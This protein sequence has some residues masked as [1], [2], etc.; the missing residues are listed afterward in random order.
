[1]RF[2]F[3][4]PAFI[5]SFSLSLLYF[6]VLSFSG[7]M[8]TY[9][10]ASNINLWQVGIIRGISTVFEVSATWIAPSLMKRIGVIRT[11]LW[12]VAWQMTWLG[13]GVAWFFYHYGHGYPSADL[14]PAVG[15]ALAVAFSR[16]GLWCFDLSMQNIVQD[17][18]STPSHVVW[19]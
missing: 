18:R 8:L 9:L 16:V 13:G 17:V 3:G 15:L 14:R 2:Y 7:Q 5:P 11:G 10:L 6:T 1:M 19:Y 12:A 4:H